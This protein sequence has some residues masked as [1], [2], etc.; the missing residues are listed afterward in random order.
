MKRMIVF[1]TLAALLISIPAVA[2][3]LYLA[4]NQVQIVD[5]EAGSVVAS[6]DI[7]KS[8]IRDMAFSSDGRTAYLAHSRGLA[9]V[10]VES[11]RVT[12]TWSDRVVN[13]LVLQEDENLLYSLQH[14]PGKSPEVVVYDLDTGRESRR[15]AVDARAWDLAVPPTG[16]RVFTTNIHTSR[17]SQFDRR[18]GSP[19]GHVQLLSSVGESDLDTYI[20]KSLASPDGRWIYVVLNGENAGIRI[21]DA[22]TGEP[23][24]RIDLG[25]TAYVRDAVLSLDG[26][27]AYLAAIDH[28]AVVDL[29]AGAE[30]AWVPVGRPH[31]GIAV[32]ADGAKLFMANPIYD[33]GGSVTIIDAARFTVIGHVEVPAISPFLVAVVP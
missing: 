13:H 23:V 28:V 2:E 10:D 31:Q 21:L 5:V 3:R 22:L 12:G 17:V 24:R 30:V 15:F 27:R 32:S 26:S 29:T 18:S 9:I 25:H 6:I 20:A 19:H 1:L 11:S 16:N 14:A 8:R 33:K 4:S 7:G